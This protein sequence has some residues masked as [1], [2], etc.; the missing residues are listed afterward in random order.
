MRP[1]RHRILVYWGLR[2][3]P[4]LQQPVEVGVVGQ[5]SAT[6][7]VVDAL[8]IGCC[9][10]AATLGQHDAAIPAVQQFQRHLLGTA[11]VVA[12]RPGA[13]LDAL[14]DAGSARSGSSVGTTPRRHRP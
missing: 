10:P 11:L 3:D 4:E 6:T 5:V 1:L 9:P 2:E 12:P 7:S 8:D 14:R 13:M